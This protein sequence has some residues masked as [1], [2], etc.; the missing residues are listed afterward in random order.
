[1][2]RMQFKAN[3]YDNLLPFHNADQGLAR[4]TTSL[5]SA[6]GPVESVN[7]AFPWPRAN[8]LVPQTSGTNEAT[9][10]AH[11]TSLFAGM[12][13]DGE[14]TRCHSELAPLT[15]AAGMAARG[16]FRGTPLRPRSALQTYA[17]FGAEDFVAPD[18]MRLKQIH[19]VAARENEVLQDTMR[20]ILAERGISNVEVCG[21]AKKADSLY[22]KLLE[23]PGETIGRIKDISG[24]RVNIHVN[25]TDYAQHY[26]VQEALQ[27]GLGERYSLGKNYIEKPNPWG[28]TGRM[29][30]FFKGKDV[31][32]HE[33]QIGSSDLSA[34][35][36]W[37][38]KNAA[39]QQRSIHDLTGYKGELYGTKLS[40]ELEQHYPRLMSEIAQN[41][42]TGRTVA[43]NPELH[44]KV[45]EFKRQVQETLPV[46]FPPKPEARV[47][48]GTQLKRLAGK[49]LGV[50]G[51]LGGGLQAWAGTMELKQ[52]K[53]AEGLA[54]VG[55]GL[56][57]AASGGAMLLGE[58][59]LGSTLGGIAAGID[60]FKD[61]YVGARDHNVE[62]AAVGGV[63]TAA[64]GMMLAGAATLNP[65]LIGAGALTYGGALL[66][67]H[68][69]ALKYLAS[70]G[71]DWADDKVS[72]A[73]A[74]ASRLGS[75]LA[76]RR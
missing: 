73:W 69:K 18:D 53:T 6:C 35:I 71:M 41:D 23:K 42:A 63:K 59:L 75:Q 65:L 10:Q 44:T 46:E 66:Y 8:P 24:V 56:T 31:P 25:Q 16:E 67:E 2:D 15:P 70:H 1:M 33:I 52:G 54:D 4:S 62:T 38:A 36:D 26:R 57:N 40:P 72:H 61:L 50:L 47:S 20:E 39:G 12:F 28:Y 32:V 43:Q 49:G 14:S 9:T 21:R 34:F 19:A 48:R 7:S 68:R 76:S 27:S 55:G 13:D 29:H 58:A 30:D 22:G 74:G 51:V 45:D 37:Q 17:G 3:N 64:G 5:R 11:R 60:G